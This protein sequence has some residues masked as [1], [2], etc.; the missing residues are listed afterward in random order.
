[1]K[2]ISTLLTFPAMVWMQN[3]QCH[4]I[5]LLYLQS[6][7]IMC[8]F[9]IILIKVESRRRPNEDEMPH[10]MQEA[11]PPPQHIIPPGMI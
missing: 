2:T 6:E 10:P 8:F 7:K 11:I 9:P 4:P 1:M 3:S 5:R